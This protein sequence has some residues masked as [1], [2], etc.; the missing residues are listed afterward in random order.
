[1]SNIQATRHLKGLEKKAFDRAIQSFPHLRAE[2]AELLTAFA[3]QS[4]RYATAKQRVERNPTILQPQFNRTTGNQ[5]G[6]KL[7]RNPEN[8]TMREA[9]T[10]LRLLER[11]LTTLN[12]KRRLEAEREEKR[13]AR[14]KPL[15]TWA[16]ERA[17][18]MAAYDLML[19]VEAEIIAGTFEVTDER[20]EDL[21]QQLTR[22]GGT[23]PPGS[24]ELREAAL[25]WIEQRY[26]AALG[27]Y[28][29]L[30][31]DSD[32]YETPTA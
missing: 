21:M 6:D 15:P 23:L 17:R 11:R 32:F 28:V 2:D 3:E 31:D 26:W 12:D 14:P 1:M 27:E 30:T 18:A 22:I 24:D 25:G 20:V 7:V 9:L 29:S 13:K 4:H 10:Q 5:I 16:S 19:S 8:A